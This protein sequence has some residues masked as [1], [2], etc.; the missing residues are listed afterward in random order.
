V[1]LLLAC[2]LLFTVTV[3]TAPKNRV[4]QILVTENAD[5][6][7]G[8]AM[9]ACFAN[10]IPTIKLASAKNFDTLE[11]RIE[12]DT[13]N[14]CVYFDPDSISLEFPTP[15]PVN[16]V[17]HVGKKITANVNPRATQQKYKYKVLMKDPAGS[18]NSYV[19]EDPE[20]DI[21]GDMPPPITKKASAPATKK[22][23]P[24]KK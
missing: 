20:L 3:E 10:T 12:S 11:W 4:L 16:N 5:Y 17:K 9:P 23:A 19:A 14:P 8:S 7:N 13:V 1:G 6:T 15:S 24:K 18:G 2:T 21:R 22:P